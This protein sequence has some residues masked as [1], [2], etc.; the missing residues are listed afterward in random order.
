ML[1]DWCSA[2]CLASQRDEDGDPC[3]LSCARAAGLESLAT[4]AARLRA[5][6][7]ALTA[8]WQRAG[9]KSRVQKRA[10]WNALARRLA[11]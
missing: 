11:N 6:V 5:S 7:P 3:C 9:L 4:A 10:T 8:A 2:P 1:C